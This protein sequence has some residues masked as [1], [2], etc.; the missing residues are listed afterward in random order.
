M[1]NVFRG[2]ML[3]AVLLGGWTL[4]GASAARAEV[5]DVGPSGP[6][7]EVFDLVTPNATAGQNVTVGATIRNRMSFPIKIRVRV[8]VTGNGQ[9]NSNQYDAFWLSGGSSTRLA[10]QVYGTQE[11]EYRVY[12]AAD[13]IEVGR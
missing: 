5:P 8:Q 10:W 9:L 11:G 1:K 4:M 7:L 2:A 3:L 6:V 13:P 12:F